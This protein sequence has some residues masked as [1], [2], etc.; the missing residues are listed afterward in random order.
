ML[1]VDQE[2][3]HALVGTPDHK[4]LWLLAREPHID[5]SVED[6]FLG[7]AVDQGYDLAKWIRPQQSG[8]VVD[9]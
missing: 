1:R 2:Y 3:Q 9:V 7:S 4:H 5:P 6:S 8:R